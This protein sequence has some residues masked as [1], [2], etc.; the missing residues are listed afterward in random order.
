MSE[1]QERTG[2]RICRALRPPP[3]CS[4]VP[5]KAANQCTLDRAASFALRSWPSSRFVIAWRVL[6]LND[7]GGLTSITLPHAIGWLRDTLRLLPRGKADEEENMFNINVSFAPCHCFLHTAQ[8]LTVPR[9]P[10]W[11]PLQFDQSIVTPWHCISHRR[12]SNKLSVEHRFWWENAVWWLMWSLH[13]SICYGMLA[14]PIYNSDSSRRIT[15]DPADCSVGF[16]P[17][18]SI[19][20]TREQNTT[21]KPISTY[22][23]H[24]CPSEGWRQTA[25][26]SCR[27]N[28]KHL[29]GR[30]LQRRW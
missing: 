13:G 30:H 17:G 4:C 19:T 21:R 3:I 12:N 28:S 11:G 16:Y 9:Y 27:R 20:C 14:Y 22:E 29:G 26:W 2:L 5:G 18:T 6:R 7:T 1:T 10:L 8:F 15:V 23:M 25:W 24:P